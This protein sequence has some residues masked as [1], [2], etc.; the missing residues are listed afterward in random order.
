V[1]VRQTFCSSII[2]SLRGHGAPCP[3]L[4]RLHPRA[5]LHAVLI[6]CGDDA[7]DLSATLREINALR[8]TLIEAQ[9]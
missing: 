9:R 2:C 4:N 6:Q 7:V 8:L 5:R 1:K 3:Y